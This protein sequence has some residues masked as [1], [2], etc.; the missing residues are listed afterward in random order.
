MDTVGNC[1]LGHSVSRC[2]GYSMGRRVTK[3]GA[4]AKSGVGLGAVE[5][6]VTGK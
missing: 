5:G 4:C 3:K 1:I 6:A 2:S